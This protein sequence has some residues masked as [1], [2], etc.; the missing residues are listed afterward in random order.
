[1][2]RAVEEHLQT[3]GTREVTVGVNECVILPATWTKT[4]SFVE[5]G[6]SYWNVCEAPKLSPDST[7]LQNSGYGRY[8]CS[9]GCSVYTILVWKGALCVGNAGGE[10]AACMWMPGVSVRERVMGGVDGQSMTMCNRHGTQLG[11]LY[12]HDNYGRTPVENLGSYNGDEFW[13]EWALHSSL[14]CLPYKRSVLSC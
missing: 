3:K 12:Y 5:G 13:S 4:Q 7:K 1:M 6:I 10:V 2:L 9:N 8:M 14:V 11:P